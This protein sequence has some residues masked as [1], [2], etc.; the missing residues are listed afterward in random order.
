MPTRTDL[1][2]RIESLVKVAVLDSEGAEVQVELLYLL[3]PLF[4][5][6]LGH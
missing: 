4:E 3:V 6:V 2:K 5:Q 1:F